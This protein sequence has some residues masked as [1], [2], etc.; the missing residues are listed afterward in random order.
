MKMKLEV[1]LE[2]AVDQQLLVV[3]GLAPAAVQAMLKAQLD[4]VARQIKEKTQAAAAT[5]CSA[6]DVAA[7]GQHPRAYEHFAPDAVERGV[8]TLSQALESQ[9]EIRYLRAMEQVRVLMEG[10]RKDCRVRCE[11]AAR[12]CEALLDR[13]IQ[14][15]DLRLPM[16]TAV[17]ERVRA[18][19]VR[20]W[21]SFLLRR[22]T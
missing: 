9:V 14:E 21:L 1:E 7:F 10:V 18:D 11:D 22:I 5:W 2:K 16:S 17:F 20:L 8:V 4:Q 15:C 19:N 13:R 12:E 6:A 3:S